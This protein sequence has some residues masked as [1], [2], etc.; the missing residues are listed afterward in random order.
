MDALAKESASLADWLSY[1][2]VLHPKVI[3]M[4]LERIDRVRA[5]LDLFPKFPVII[6]GGTNGKGSVC[7]MLESILQSAGYKVGC[8]TSPHLLHYNE[9][10]RI[11]KINIDDRNLCNAFAQ[12]DAARKQCDISLTYF[13]FGTLAAMHC[14]MEAQVDVAIMEI[15]LGGR[16]DAVNIFDPDCAILTS[17]ELDHI[18]YLGDTREKIGFEKAAIFRSTKPAVYADSNI[19]HSVSQYAEKINAQFIRF[20]EEFGYINKGDQWD[21]WGLLGERRSLPF[22]ALRGEKQLQNASACLAALDSLRELLPVK[23]SDIRQGLLDAVIPGRFQVVSTQPMII[24]DVAHNPSAAVVL[25][26][27][28]QATKS[29]GKTYAVVA[30]LQDKDILGVVQSLK[31]DIDYWLVSTVKSPRAASADFLLQQIYHSGINNTDQCVKFD[32]CVAAF[33]FACEQ[34]SKDDRICVFGS[35]YT[36]SEILHFMKT[37]HSR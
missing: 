2:E 6:V 26:N 19:P 30:M 20:E 11:N 8:Y 7:T 17:V 13:E 23:M 37:A 33:V 25:S 36:V 4:G 10:I 29:I 21:F 31:K 32:D 24:L 5:V 1:L 15:G 14:F 18:D 22:P 3:D 9:R 12:I 28:L 16:L 35:F 34:A 27:N